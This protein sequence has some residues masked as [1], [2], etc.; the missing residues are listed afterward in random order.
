MQEAVSFGVSG[1]SRYVISTSGRLSSIARYQKLLQEK[2]GLDIVYLPISPKDDHQIIEPDDFVN[3]IK[4]LGAIGGAI[5]KDIKT[6]VI[7]FLDELDESA[8]QVQ[9]VNTVLRKG[10]KLIGYNTDVMGFRKAIEKGIAD[11]GLS[12]HSAVI[13]G[14]GGVFNVANS[15]LQGM[16]IKT[17]VS[18]RN[19]EKV[20]A[21]AARFGLDPF[22]GESDLFVNATPVTD[23]PLHE[24]SGFL[25]ALSSSK[26]AFDHHMPGE[27]LKIFCQNQSKFYIPGTAM[28]YPQMMAQ[29]KIFLQGLVDPDKVE[30]KLRS[31]I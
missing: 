19:D 23:T 31:L 29:W 27:Q 30:E 6:R 5:S 10:P 1:A 7:P 8:Q 24:A 14:Y 11:S 16:G 4:G 9:S 22:E 21:T 20:A 12:I 15:V 25:E 3:A 28:Y 2:L 13:Y 26:M 18:G 17:Y